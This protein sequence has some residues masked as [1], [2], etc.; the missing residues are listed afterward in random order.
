MRQNWDWNQFKPPVCVE[1]DDLRLHV[2]DG[3]H[4]SIAAATHNALQNFT[5]PKQ[6][7]ERI[8]RIPVIVVEA[9][10]I[11]AR[12]KAFIGQTPSALASPRTSSSKPPVPP[13]TRMP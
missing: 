13:A 9:S 2:I 8:G 11:E 3:Q 4:T 7:S 6:N 1:D 5:V 10:S 12:A